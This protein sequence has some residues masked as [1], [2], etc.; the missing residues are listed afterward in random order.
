M[1]VQ[2]MERFLQTAADRGYDKRWPFC[3]D[4]FHGQRTYERADPGVVSVLDDE[5]LKTIAQHTKV[6]HLG[7]GRTDIP[8]EAHIPT[9]RELTDVL[10]H[11]TFSGKTKVILE[12]LKES[13]ML[14]HIVVE[15]TAGSLRAAGCRKREDLKRAYQQIAAATREFM[16]ET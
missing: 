3:F 7:L 5:T 14:Q 8:G 6:A 10:R 1:G 12:A 2:S 15:A 4:T 9:Q 13:G 11:G 16:A